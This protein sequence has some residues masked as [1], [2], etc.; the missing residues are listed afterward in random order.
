MIT[1]ILI[2]FA[3]EILI[4]CSKLKHKKWSEFL[5]TV[6]AEMRVFLI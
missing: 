1:A 2:I 3:G 5:P 6:I 4:K